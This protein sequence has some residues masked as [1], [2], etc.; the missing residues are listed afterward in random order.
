MPLVLRIRYKLI[1]SSPFRI[2]NLIYKSVRDV[3]GHV[4]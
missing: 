2:I 4:K 3:G 1:N